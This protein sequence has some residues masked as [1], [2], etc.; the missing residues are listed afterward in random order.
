MHSYTHNL[1]LTPGRNRWRFFKLSER[2]ESHR[3]D[4]PLHAGRISLTTHFRTHNFAY[5]YHPV[6]GGTGGA[7]IARD[8]LSMERSPAIATCFNTRG[9]ITE[10]VICDPRGSLLYVHTAPISRF[11]TTFFLSLSTST[12]YP[13]PFPSVSSGCADVRW[14]ATELHGGC[15]SP[16]AC[17]KRTGWGVR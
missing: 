1:A 15:D 10:P 11:V 17:V 13:Q 6:V 2:V 7:H 12:A 9:Y 8:V 14:T 16:Q 3:G 4:E 5:G